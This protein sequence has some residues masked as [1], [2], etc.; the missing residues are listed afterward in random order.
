MGAAVDGGDGMWPADH[1]N[2]LELNHRIHDC[3]EQLPCEPQYA[4]SSQGRLARYSYLPRSTLG[5]DRPRA[6]AISHAPCL[7]ES[8]R[9]ERSGSEGPRAENRLRNRLL[10]LP[11]VDIDVAIRFPDP[12]RQHN[13]S[14]ITGRCRITV[15]VFHLLYSAYNLGM[16]E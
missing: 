2:K 7:R 3:G 6:P 1:R 11:R 5:C 16:A 8:R 15:A 4:R 10:I 14:L 12:V 13:S 9:R